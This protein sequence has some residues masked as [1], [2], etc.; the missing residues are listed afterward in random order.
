MAH[1]NAISQSA[2]G[3]LSSVKDSD[4]QLDY[5]F[6]WRDWLLD[7][8]DTIAVHETLT[9]NPEGAT[10]PLTVVDSTMS[11]GIVTVFVTGGTPGSTHQLTCR[12]TTTNGTP[13]VADKTLNLKIKEH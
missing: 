5:P 12:I 8:S 2:S 10:I 6:D 13:R 9:V 1:G 3:K 4:E 7:V 11:Q